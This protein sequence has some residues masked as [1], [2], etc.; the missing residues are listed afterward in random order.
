MSFLNRVS[1]KTYGRVEFEVE[2]RNSLGLHARPASMI[3]QAASQFECDIKILKDG[4]EVNGKSLMGVLMLA[5][6]KGSR[7]RIVAD[8]SDSEKA[9]ESL[10]N[11]IEIRKFD[12]N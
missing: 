1:G 11:L 8:G 3:V 5:A 7:L 6:G 12:E 10:H 2:I 4:A 9:R